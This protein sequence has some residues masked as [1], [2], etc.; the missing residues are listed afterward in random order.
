MS[1][2]GAGIRAVMYK[3][4]G[5][6]LVICASKNGRSSPVFSMIAASLVSPQRQ[7]ISIQIQK[8]K[9]MNSDQGSYYGNVH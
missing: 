5:L 3:Y 7:L 9:S 8:L 6:S 2:D 1:F 4:V